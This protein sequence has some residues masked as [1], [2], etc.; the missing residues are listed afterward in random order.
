MIK[1]GLKEIRVLA[2]TSK[3]SAFKFCNGEALFANCK[4]HID[5]AKS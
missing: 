4:A 2:S 1:Y 5:L 3:L